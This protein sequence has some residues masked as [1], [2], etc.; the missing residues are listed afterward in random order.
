MQQ[1]NLPE[2][3]FRTRRESDKTKI[4]D[5][6]R[7]KWVAL[8]PEEWVRQNFLRFLIEQYG[9]LP[10]K[11]G[12]EVGVSI[13]QKALRVDGAV[14][15]TFGNIK[16]LLEFK[17]PSVNINEKVFSQIADYNTKI[18]AEYV[19]VS[20][21]ISHY[22]MQVGTEVPTLLDKIPEYNELIQ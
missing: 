17:A 12:V 16:M 2:Y 9:Y 7:K 14:Y 3:S 5:A 21:G 1:L 18:G 10:G 15:D 11:I 19:I 20:N 22:C 4:F 6:L 8:T 13:N